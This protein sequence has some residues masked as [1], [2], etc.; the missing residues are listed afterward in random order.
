EGRLRPDFIAS[1]ESV[2]QRCPEV[3]LVSFWVHHPE[4]DN[5]ALIKPCPSFPYQW[6]ANG[7]VP[8]SVIRTEALHEAGNFR[9]PMCQ[10]YEDWDLF[11]AVMAAGWIAVTVPEILADYPFVENSMS[12]DTVGHTYVRMRKELLERFPD[13][14]ARDAK[15]IVLLAES[16]KAWSPYRGSFIPQKQRVVAHAI[17]MARIAL[18]RPRWTTLAVL[19]TLKKKALRC[20]PLWISNLISRVSS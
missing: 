2:L 11:N 17:K 12:L 8:F 15:D 13:L 9:S 3:G 10:G 16:D 1:C 7:A 4:N 18:L 6:H 14:V 19:K 5:R 20:T